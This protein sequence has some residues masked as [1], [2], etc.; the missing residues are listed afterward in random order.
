MR[1]TIDLK[2]YKVKIE[3]TEK[4]NYLHIEVYDEGGEIIDW[5]TISDDDGEEDEFQNLN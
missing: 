3:Y 1:K 5:I 4:D 2:Q